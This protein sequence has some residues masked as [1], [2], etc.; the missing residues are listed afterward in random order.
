MQLRQ[1][2]PDVISN[3]VVR[4]VECVFNEILD[5]QVNYRTLLNRNTFLD[6]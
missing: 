4:F 1:S 3:V 2:P 5:A 6:S